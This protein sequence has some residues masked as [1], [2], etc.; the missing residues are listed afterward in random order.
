[1]AGE[2]TGISACRY[3]VTIRPTRQPG[4]P[5][6]IL[7]RNATLFRLPKQAISGLADLETAF[8]EHPLRP[9]GPIEVSTTGFVPPKDGDAALSLHVEHAVLFALGFEEKVLP[10]ATVKAEIAKRVKAYTA[11]RGKPPGGK[12]R[13]EI[14]NEALDVLLP[15]AMVKPSRVVAYIDMETGWVVVDTTSTKRAEQVLTAVRSALGSFPTVPVM[16]STTSPRVVMTQWL[17]RRQLPDGLEF[18]D[19][20]EM[21]EPATGAVARVGKQQ[22]ES[23]EIMAHLKSGKQCMKLGLVFNDHV[24]FVLREN[25]SLAKIHLLEGALESLDDNAEDADAAFYASLTLMVGESGEVF[26][27]MRSWFEIEDLTS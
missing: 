8:A 12:A 2:V 4:T 6:S 25:L 5:V 10:A 24:S 13:R 3:R 26:A 27:A 11:Q 15:K 9:C 19:E 7:F 18:G 22:L 23:D 21:K 16:S 14:K 20:C 17:A 1:M